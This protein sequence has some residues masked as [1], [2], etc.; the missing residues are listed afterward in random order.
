MNLYRTVLL[1]YL[2]AVSIEKPIETVK[3]L[4]ESNHR[5]IHFAGEVTESLKNS[6]RQEYRDMYEKIKQ[7]DWI[8][9]MSRLNE[10]RQD[11]EA[12]I[13]SYMVKTYTIYFIN[14]VAIKKT[15]KPLYR[16]IKEPIV[17]GK[18][19]NILPKNGPLTRTFEKYILRAF[20]HGV[21]MKLRYHYQL[22]EGKIH[23]TPKV[24]YVQS[25]FCYRCTFGLW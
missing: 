24:S 5:H 3:E 6:S 14:S 16:R 4:L 2:T 13:G 18:S 22:R 12:G 19:S 11:F 9:D 25:N 21:F 8:V 20:D 7:N 15:G 23:K 10:T 1:S 17:T